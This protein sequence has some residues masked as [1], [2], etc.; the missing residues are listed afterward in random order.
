MTEVIQRK[1]FPYQFLFLE[2][3]ISFYA[4]VQRKDSHLIL[5]FLTNDVI[6]GVFFFIGILAL[7]VLGIGYQT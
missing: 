1:K 4:L 3:L 2:R 5:L 7:L 6:C